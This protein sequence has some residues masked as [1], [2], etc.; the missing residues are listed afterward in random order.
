MQLSSGAL[1][2]LVLCD[3][4]G[5]MQLSSGALNILRYYAI[6]QWGLKR[7]EIILTVTG[8]A[9]NFDINSDERDKIL[10]GMMDGTRDLRYVCEKSPVKETNDVQKRPI[11]THADLSPWFI[12][13]GTNA[14][15][16]LY[17]FVYQFQHK[18]LI[19]CVRQG[20]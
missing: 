9:T 5:T 18:G 16:G 14:G 7:P 3:Y 10:K 1:N 15:K 11:L 6:K 4:A 2:I 17:V 8:G 12:T 13:G 19:R 20:S